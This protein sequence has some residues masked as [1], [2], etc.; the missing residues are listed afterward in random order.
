MQDLRELPPP[1]CVPRASKRHSP[2]PPPAK[3]LRS[4]AHCFLA[5][6]LPGPKMV[7]ELQAA[8]LRLLETSRPLQCPTSRAAYD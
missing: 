2:N 5:K 7:A 8:Y 4:G 3:Y 1:L 6:D